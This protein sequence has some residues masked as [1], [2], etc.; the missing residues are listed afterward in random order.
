MDF[1]EPYLVYARR[2]AEGL[3]NAQC[4]QQDILA[5]NYADSSFDG[6]LCSGVLDTMP[7]PNLASLEMNRVL[8]PDGKLIWT[9][10]IFLFTY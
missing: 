8:K 5:M 1:S 6:I 4:E 7:E 9:T 10:R 2:R 3:A